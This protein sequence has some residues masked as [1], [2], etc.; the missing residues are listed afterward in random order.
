MTVNDII[1]T[2]CPGLAA[3]ANLTNYVTLATQLTSTT[4]FGVNTTFAIALR[5]S[6]MWAMKQRAMASATGGSVTQI[7][8]GK[9]SMSFQAIQGNVHSDLM[10]TTYGQQL[11]A[12]M[13]PG[14]SVTGGQ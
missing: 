8:E 5:A 12:L 10:S 9:L 13:G 6:H 4:F 14:I 11:K 3:D 1:S 7:T 2:L